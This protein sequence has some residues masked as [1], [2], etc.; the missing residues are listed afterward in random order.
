MEQKRMKSEGAG[1]S[2]DVVMVVFGVRGRRKILGKFIRNEV[3]FEM[4]A[5]VK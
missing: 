2:H 5:E 4:R 3:Y 1:G